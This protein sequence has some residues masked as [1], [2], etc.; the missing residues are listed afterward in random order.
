[1]KIPFPSSV[2]FF[3]EISSISDQEI[4]KFLEFFF[5]PGANSTNFTNF[6]VKF[7]QIFYIKKRGKK[8][9]HCESLLPTLVP[10]LGR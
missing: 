8:K 2:F 7:R 9:T 6:S 1:V 10:N 5:F 4:G 3:G